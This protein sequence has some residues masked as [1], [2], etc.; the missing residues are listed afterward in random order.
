MKTI[1]TIA[2]ILAA[3]RE[4]YR[5]NAAAA[6]QAVSDLEAAYRETI[7]ETPTA[8]VAAYVKRVGYDVAVSTVATLVNRSASDGRITRRCAEWAASQEN[9]FDAEAAE[10]LW[11]Y[12]DRIHK[13]HLD[14]IAAAMMEYRPEDVAEESAGEPAHAPKA[15]PQEKSPARTLAY[16]RALRNHLQTLACQVNVHSKEYRNLCN[17]IAWIYD[18]RLTWRA[19]AATQAELPF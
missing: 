18:N 12:S 13:T 15:E 3:S 4:E 16:W 5:A 6:R 1:E 9:A 17:R 7:D 10:R 19:E 11:L 8:T 14:Q 2:A